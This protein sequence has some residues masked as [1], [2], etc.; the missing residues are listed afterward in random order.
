MA[1]IPACIGVGAC[2]QQQLDHAAGQAWLVK[3]SGAFDVWTVR[4]YTPYPQDM[5][6]GSHIVAGSKQRGVV[7][8]GWP[9]AFSDQI[10]QGAM[11]SGHRAIV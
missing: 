3:E 4:V 10:Q 6:H 1:A 9:C 8:M 2:G 11:C 7:G 5:G